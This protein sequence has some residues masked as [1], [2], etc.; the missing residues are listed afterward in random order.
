MDSY[1]VIVIGAG[2]TGCATAWALSADNLRILVLDR[3]G[4]AAM[5]SGWTLAGVRQSGRDPAELPLALAAVKLW[6]TLHEELGAPTGYVRG[7]NL[8]LAR[9]EAE[10]ARIRAMVDAQSNQGLDLTFLPDTAA[11][12]AVAPAV[13]PMIPG[14]SLCATDGHADP[15][16]T[17]QAYVAALKRRG[18]D[19]AMGETVEALEVS[20]AR[21][22]GVRTTQRRIGAGR[23]ILATGAMG[24]EL[25][26]PLGL[27]VPLDQPM[28]AVIR[29]VPVAPVLAHVIG[30]AGGDWAGRQE[31]SGRLRLTSG[32][33]PWDGTMDIEQ[34]PEGPRPR[35]RPPLSSLHEVIAKLDQ[36]LPGLS[37]AAVDEVWSGL[38][39]L[40]P[41]ALPVLSTAPGLEGLV[42]G[43]GFSGHG[44]GLGPV[45]GQIL[46]DLALDRAPALPLE[47]FAH[48]R[49]QNGADARRAPLTL[50]G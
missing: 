39:D 47:A 42:I 21:V 1:D 36:Y 14:A 49:F 11:I 20:G 29:T 6:S 35:V 2:I 7:G 41:D 5:A 30:V 19:F 48:A 18:V 46:A 24:N 27:A 28:V 17:S 44:F 23:M 10:Y 50:H 8:R 40:T 31:T 38:I 25:L 22:T 33:L 26:A 13:S 15:Q 37:A 32:M 34:R 9:N 45:S 4:P 16:A 12:K 43:M 3:F